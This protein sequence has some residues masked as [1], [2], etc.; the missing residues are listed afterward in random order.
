MLWGCSV[1]AVLF[2]MVMLRNQF[3]KQHCIPQT[4]ELPTTII[5]FMEGFFLLDCVLVWLMIDY[6][7]PVQL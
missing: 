6:W 1:F 7:S 4:S 5:S 2:L 3:R